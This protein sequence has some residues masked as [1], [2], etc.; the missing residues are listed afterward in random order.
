VSPACTGQPAGRAPVLVTSYAQSDHRWSP[1]A[2]GYFW[3]ERT[4]QNGI[5]FGW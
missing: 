5:S 2:I 3:M 1:F 4:S